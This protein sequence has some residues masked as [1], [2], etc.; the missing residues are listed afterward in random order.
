MGQSLAALL[1]NA[2]N[3]YSE[4][5]FAPILKR[6][7]DIF[8]EE[9]LQA[10]KNEDRPPCYSAKARSEAFGTSLAVLK[11]QMYT[12]MSEALADDWLLEYPED[13]RGDSERITHGLI[14]ELCESTVNDALKILN[15]YKLVLDD[16]DALWRRSHPDLNPRFPKL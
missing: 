7:L 16:A 9:L 6:Y 2:F 10:I 11:R 5:R 15:D 14:D 3:G 13:A 1:L 8:R 12:E 4:L